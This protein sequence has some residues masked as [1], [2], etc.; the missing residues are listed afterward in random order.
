ML[1]CAV[2]KHVCYA[3]SPVWATIC[4]HPLQTRQTFSPPSRDLFTGV[5]EDRKGSLLV[6]WPCL[7]L[8][9]RNKSPSSGDRRNIGICGK[10]CT[11]RM[12]NWNANA[13]TFM[14]H[15]CQTHTM[16]RTSSYHTCSLLIQTC[17]HTY[18][19]IWGPSGA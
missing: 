12:I 8:P 13:A 6:C 9:Q 7:L 1:K 16:H 5:G 19:L 14:Y 15:T 10:C 3:A 11:G 2:I 18:L 17:K 4:V